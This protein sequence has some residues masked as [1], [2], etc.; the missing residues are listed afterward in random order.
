MHDKKTVSKSLLSIAY[1]SLLITAHSTVQ[2]SGFAV[3]EMNIAGMALSNALVANPHVLAAIAYNPAAMAFHDGSSLAVGL[4]LLKSDIS[5]D[6]GSG[7]VDSATNGTTAIPL[8]TAHATLNESWAI[9]LALNTPFGLE[10]EW[11]AGTFDSQYPIES[12]IPTS[13]QLE[14][15]SFSPS[16][17]YKINDNVSVAG[18]LDLYWLREVIFNGDINLGLEPGSN[19][20][21]DLEGDGRGVGFNLSLMVR[22]DNWTFGGNYHAETRI[23]VEGTVDLPAD[24]LPSY[25]SN[26]VNAELNLPYRLQLGVHN[27]TTDKLALEFDFTRTGWSSF[28]RL[29]VKQNQFGTNIVTSTNKWDDSNTYRLSATYDISDDTQLRAGYTFDESPQGDEFF[30]PRVPNADRQLFSLGIGHTLTNDWTI[31]ASYMYLK[32]D[33]R[34]VDV[35]PSFVHSAP[36][37]G[38]TNGTSAVNGD[39]ESSAHLFGMGVTKKFM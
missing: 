26:K 28:D 21:A 35:D 10:T 29:V 25:F 32:S 23:P 36:H 1:G 27:Q 31:D 6:T 9:S 17:A 30:S 5:V 11:P 37:S 15:A 20:A 39:Y 24:L 3:P 22:Q 7:S 14:I 18:G 19:P 4:M 33:K 2:A 38:E 34:K 13:S 8:L 16:V 12:T